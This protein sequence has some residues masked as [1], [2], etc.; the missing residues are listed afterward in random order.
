[1]GVPLC[2]QR[3][4]KTMPFKQII[5]HTNAMPTWYRY[6]SH[7]LFWHWPPFNLFPSSCITFSYVD[8]HWWVTLCVQRPAI[9]MPFRQII[10]YILQ[11]PHDMLIHLFC[12][13]IHKFNLFLLR[14]HAATCPTSNCGCG[15]SLCA[16]LIKVEVKI[17]VLDI[18][19]VID[20][21]PKEFD[22]DRSKVKVTETTHWGLKVKLNAVYFIL[23]HWNGTSYKC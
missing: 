1:M 20:S 17:K 6:A 21:S 14:S 23:K 13:D 12:F 9:S 15:T 5:M 18:Y 16:I 19:W 3:P 2:V 11:C 4:A 10:M 7:I 22:L 8:S